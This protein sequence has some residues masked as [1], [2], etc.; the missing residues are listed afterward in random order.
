MQELKFRG[1]YNRKP[2]G[3]WD[4]AYPSGNGTE[5]ILVMGEPYDETIIFNHE[6]LFLPVPVNA[7]S[8]VPDM[9]DELPAV[10]DMIRSGRCREATEYYLKKIHEKGFPSELLWTDPFHPA[11][12]L[13]IKT[14]KAG[15]TDNY[16]RRLD[17][18][19]GETVVSWTDDCGTVERRAFV[20]RK[21]NAAVIRLSMSAGRPADSS[22]EV[23]SYAGDRTEYCADE[24][25]YVISLAE[26]KGG[27][28]IK[29]V[30]ISACGTD[31]LIWAWQESAG[32]KVDRPEQ[33]GTG[34]NWPETTKIKSDRPEPAKIKSDRT[35]SA[36]S[37]K[38][39]NNQCC[40]QPGNEKPESCRTALDA[41]AA[42]DA[43]LLFRCLYEVGNG[44]YCGIVRLHTTGGNVKIRDNAIEIESTDEVLIA[45]RVVPF[46]D[47]SLFSLYAQAAELAQIPA[48]YGTLLQEHVAIHGELFG[49]MRLDLDDDPDKYALSNEELMDLADKGIF[50]PAFMEKMHDLGRYL[51]ISSSGQLPPNLQGVWN[52]SWNPPWSSDYTL[53]ENLQMMMWPVM[54]GNMPE[55]AQ[56]YFSLIESYVED[57]KTNAGIFYGCRGVMAGS[58]SSTS[59]LHKHFCADFPMMFWTAGAGWLAQ[60]FYDYW[61][62]TGDN[63]FL[64]EHTVP[65]LREVALFYED[66]LVMGSDGKYEFIPSYSPENTPSNSDSPAAINA[67]MDIAVAKEVLTNL[68]SACEVLD[69]A[70]ENI[71]KWRKMLERMPDYMINSDGALKEW[72]HPAFEDDYHHRHSS[73][74]YPVFPGFEVTQESTPELYRACLRAAELRLTDGIEAITGWGLAHLANISARLK[75]GELSF[76]ALCRIIDKF[77]LPNLFTCH[78]EGEL[79]Q[80]D[81]NLGFTAAIM[82]MLVFSVP[83]LIELL[84]ALPAQLSKGSVS[85]MLCRGCI[86]L[87]ELK[88]DIN[89]RFISAV[90]R[91]KSEQSV[92]VRVPGTIA[93]YRVMAGENQEAI[94]CENQGVTSIKNYGAMHGKNN[95]II[96]GEN[97]STASDENRKAISDENRAA[98]SCE[99]RNSHEDGNPDRNPDIGQPWHSSGI[100]TSCADKAASEIR[101][102]LKK[103]LP[104]KLMVQLKE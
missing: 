95:W 102:S 44:G 89:G 3:K 91:S 11:F 82:E 5:G 9:A 8:T 85:G 65:L 64:R 35:E 75:D 4:E 21:R 34:Y 26:R 92:R 23:L 31:N 37:G 50:P 32:A 70:K 79:F 74:L 96:A 68:I 22:A 30:V 80:M 97:K 2:A 24:A 61:Q 15:S 16:C 7:M 67:T 42:D 28:H 33:A 51:L 59:G 87:D 100:D 52:G 101:I 84:P 83:G 14:R 41:A 77:L 104:V 48:D 81:A 55:L 10:R 73:H 17:F 57:W 63:E 18:S 86:T 43:W 39:A 90:F 103:D 71:P 47:V 6:R 98:A 62:F 19:T 36:V 29:P 45:A 13:R 58:R 54:P 94:S 56:S 72:S 38:T 53:D 25:A 60:M 20:S 66:F 69:I 46:A 76:K 99:N 40:G 27:K 1:M 93:S 12:D 88:W 78:N 49:R